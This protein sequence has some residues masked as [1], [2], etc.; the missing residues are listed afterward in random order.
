M[1]TNVKELKPGAS[2]IADLLQRKPQEEVLEP[3]PSTVSSDEEKFAAG[4][5]AIELQAKRLSG[6]QRK[7]LI[8]ERKMKKGTWMKEKSN[9]KNPPSQDKGKAG[10]SGGVKR[11]HS[12][13]STPSQEKQQPKKPRSTQVQTGTYKEAAAGIKMVIIHRL[14]PDVHLDQAQTDIIQQKLLNVVDANPL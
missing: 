12:A 3:K 10:S 11:P 2:K 6:A 9:R 13:L 8:K 14:H 5:S 1:D 7:K 4:I